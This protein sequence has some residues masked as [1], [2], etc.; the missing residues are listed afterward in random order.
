MSTIA[1]D[2][3]PFLI[4]LSVG[5][6]FSA[7]RRRSCNASHHRIAVAQTK[8]ASFGITEWASLTVKGTF[9]YFAAPERDFS[10]YPAPSLLYA[11]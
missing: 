6:L 8:N 10:A 5:V 2:S 4:C 11:H 9:Q 1:T 7:R 3:T